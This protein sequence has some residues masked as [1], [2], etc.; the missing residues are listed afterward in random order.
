[1]TTTP[2]A[3]A[4][5]AQRLGVEVNTAQ[6]T[7]ATMTTTR[8][9]ATVD[10]KTAGLAVRMAWSTMPTVTTTPE[11]ATVDVIRAAIEVDTQATFTT[12]PPGMVNAVAQVRFLHA[13]ATIIKLPAHNILARFTSMSADEYRD[14]SHNHAALIDVST[15]IAVI[16]ASIA[17]LSALST[18]LTTRRTMH[19]D[20]RSSLAHINVASTTNAQPTTDA[21]VIH[22][23]GKTL[24]ESRGSRQAWKPMKRRESPIKQAWIDV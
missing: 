13:K 11:A 4:I 22:S 10:A 12:V 20:S 24:L 2:E 3:A 18:L 19:A 9:A 21:V 8:E 6:S 15:L 23:A 5:D 14:R 1:M 16:F 7:M 17:C